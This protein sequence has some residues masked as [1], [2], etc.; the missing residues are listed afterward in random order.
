MHAEA[1]LPLHS[2][3]AQ[4]RPSAVKEYNYPQ[5]FKTQRAADF[6]ADEMKPVPVSSCADG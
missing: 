3:R 2:A 6:D 1:A 5:W 4:P